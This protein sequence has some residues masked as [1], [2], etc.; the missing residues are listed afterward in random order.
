M[1]LKKAERKEKYPEI[2][3]LMMQG[4]NKEAFEKLKLT[5][6]EDTGLFC[7]YD[8]DKAMA[9]LDD[10]KCIWSQDE[11]EGQDWSSSCGTGFT[12]NNDAPNDNSF[13]FCP[14]CSK[15]LEEHYNKVDPID[16]DQAL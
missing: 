9:K 11:E 4:K 1:P 5:C 16:C 7:F 8:Y 13:H 12:F 10:E 3:S 15:P 14:N 6:G 2:M